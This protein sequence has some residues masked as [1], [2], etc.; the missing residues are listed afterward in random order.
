MTCANDKMT[1]S[2]HQLG[3]VRRG[4]IMNNTNEISDMYGKCK[5]SH[6]LHKVLRRWA[7][8]TWNTFPQIAFIAGRHLLTPFVLFI[9]IVPIILTLDAPPIFLAGFS[10]NAFVAHP[11]PATV[12]A[13]SCRRGS[14][15][16]LA[17]S[18]N[19]KMLSETF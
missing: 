8:C 16:V 1:T 9:R 5:G 12:L 6:T 2:A 3:F 10:R 19:P 7:V 4:H 13:D 18:A 17:I 11:F 15:E 14:R